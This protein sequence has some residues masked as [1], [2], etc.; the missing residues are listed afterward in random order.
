MNYKIVNNATMFDI[1]EIQ[2]DNIIKTFSNKMKHAN[3]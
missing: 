2:T 1:V 3:F